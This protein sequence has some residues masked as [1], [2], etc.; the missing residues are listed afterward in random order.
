M[1]PVYVRLFN[2]VL[3]SGNVPELWLYGIIV[4]SIHKNKGDPFNP[5]NYRGLTILS[6]LGKLFTLIIN[7]RLT[8]YCEE[9]GTIKLNQALRF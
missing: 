5:R 9:N 4:S 6:C 1:M 2:E 8:K 3:D 7:K